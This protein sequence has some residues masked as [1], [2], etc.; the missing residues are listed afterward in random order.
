MENKYYTPKLG[1]D[2]EVWKEQKPREL[3]WRFY[4]SA[5][6]VQRVKKM[7]SE[8]FQEEMKNVKGD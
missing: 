8:I 6:T 1:Q 3:K 5:E 2:D 4:G 7:F